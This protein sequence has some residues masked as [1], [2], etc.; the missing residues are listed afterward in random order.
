[1]QEEERKLRLKQLRLI[2]IIMLCVF[3]AMLSYT[4]YWCVDY[5]NQYS[6]YQQVE[7]E[8]I[9]HVII[10]DVKYDM[11]EYQIDDRVYNR[12][13]TKYP[14]KNDIGDIVTIYFIGFMLS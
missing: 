4:I 11:L 8:V 13:T 5:N 3:V 12:H 9:Q 7:S 10:D 6:D 2:L 14:S 1:M